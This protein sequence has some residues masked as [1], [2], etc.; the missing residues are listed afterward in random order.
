MGFKFEPIQ[1][2]IRNGFCIFGSI[3]KYS[4]EKSLGRNDEFE[5]YLC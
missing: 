2:Y 1:E 4:L 5:N 3:S